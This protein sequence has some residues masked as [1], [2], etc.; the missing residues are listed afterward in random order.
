MKDKFKREFGA[1]IDDFFDEDTAATSEIN[2]E[3]NLSKDDFSLGDDELL[4]QLLKA[5]EA[6]DE[7]DNKVPG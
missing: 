2:K 7:I 6:I 1:T 4:D 5:N 3:E